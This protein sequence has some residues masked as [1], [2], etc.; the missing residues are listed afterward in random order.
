MEVSELRPEM[1]ASTATIRENST[2]AE[3]IVK[4][5]LDKIVVRDNFNVRSEFGDIEALAYSMI[6]NGQ[7]VPGRVDALADGTFCL[8]DGHRR[9]KAMQ[10]LVDMGHE[11]LF[12]AI[13][14]TKKTTEEQR[15]LQM[16]ATQDNKPLLP[17]EVA[18]LINR[19]INLGYNQTEV[20]KK[21][22]RTGAYISQMLNYV[23]ESPLIKQE[24]NEGNITVAAVLDLQKKIP[25]STERL[26]A[27]KTAVSKK[28]EDA[29]SNGKDTKKPAPVSANEVIGKKD[30]GAIAIQIAKEIAKTYSAELERSDL[31]AM[32]AII[33]PYL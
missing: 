7:I 6:E 17:N 12:K 30:K 22:G 29:K 10:L 2:R 24:V 27:I 25:N 14:N 13:V 18:E 33:K 15:I 9:F 23:T 28:K 20:A 5:S 8:I 19:L 11:P 26:E 31:K 1:L 21:L 3:E 32:V 4:I 16:F